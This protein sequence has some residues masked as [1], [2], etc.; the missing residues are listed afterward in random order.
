MKIL[1]IDDEPSITES[2]KMILGIKDYEVLTAPDGESGLSLLNP[3]FDVVFTG[4]KLGAGKMDGLEVLKKVKESYPYIPVAIVSA[5]FTKSIHAEALSLGALE[6]L[7][8]PFLT[9]EIYELIERGT[10]SK[11]Q[12]LKNRDLFDIQVDRLTSLLTQCEM[13]EMRGNIRPAIEKCR[14]AIKIIPH[15]KIFLKMGRLYKKINSSLVVEKLNQGLYFQETQGLGA[16]DVHE[17]LRAGLSPSEI[18]YCT[19]CWRPIF[20]P[21]GYENLE[22]LCPKCKNLIRYKP[23]PKGFL[24]ALIKIFGFYD[25]GFKTERPPIEPP[26]K[27]EILTPEKIYPTV[28]ELEAIPYVPSKAKRKKAMDFEETDLEWIRI[29]NKV[30]ERDDYKCRVCRGTEDLHVHHIIPRS[31]GGEDEPE[32]LI[33]LCEK[34]HRLQS[35]FGHRIIGKDVSFK[36]PIS[37]RVRPIIKKSRKQFRY[38]LNLIEDGYKKHETLLISYKKPIDDETV[39]NS[40]RNIDVY[41]IKKGYIGCF[42]HIRNALRTFKISRIQ[43]IYHTG[44]H[45]DL[46]PEILNEIENKDFWKELTKIS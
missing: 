44:K 21:K 40:R 26:A 6:Y 22:F 19:D 4:F 46:K 8:K 33:T 34:C 37:I 45:F 16:K 17:A 18:V 38:I 25:Y 29:R 2:F 10:K 9:E 41:L 35:G 3:S 23:Q 43:G 13:E 5:Y 14:E 36:R 42:C 32:N 20:I 1:V 24:D 27:V 12:Y 15:P 11:S 28:R 39:E 31:E 7:R 30:K